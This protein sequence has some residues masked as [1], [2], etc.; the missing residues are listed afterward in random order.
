M[1][2]VVQM[3]ID[4]FYMKIAYDEA[5]KCLDIDE[6]PVGAIIVKDDQIIAA[7]HNT[8]ETTQMATAHAET[9]AIMEAC[10]KLKSW[11]LDDCTLY[12][13]LE[14]CLMCSGA[15][16]SSRI[17][18]VVYGTREYRW[19]ALDRIIQDKSSINHHPE[20]TSGIMEQEC[21][22]IIKDYFKN[23]R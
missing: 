12:T 4:E 17:K 16:V 22:Q 5:M 11:R 20:I 15:I 13:T 10:S 7:A 18:R 23:K 19:I 2:V 14:P 6:V 9:L 8:R 3:N 1:G 21:S